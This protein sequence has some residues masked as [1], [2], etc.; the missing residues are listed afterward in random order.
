MRWRIPT[1][2]FAAFFAAALVLGAQAPV[3]GEAAQSV[4]CAAQVALSEQ[5]SSLHATAP[6]HPWD[7]CTG[8][9]AGRSTT[10]D[11]SIIFA[12][13]ED[14]GE[15]DIDFLWYIPRR[16]HAPGSV[17]KLQNGGAVPQVE[18]TYAYFWDQC[19]GTSFSNNIVNKWGVSLGSN[20]CPSRED[21]VEEVA[22]R[23]D[24]VDGGLAFELRIILAERAKT[25]REA[26]EIAARLLDTYG[27]NASGRCLHIVGPDEAW[28]LQMVRGKQY[29]ARRVQDDEVAII[30]NTYSIREVDPED[31]ENFICSPR[32]IEY[33]TER[34]WYDPE[35]G[36]PFDFAAAYADPAAH[37][38][39]YNTDRHWN[40]AR[41]LVKDFPITWKEARTGVLP[42]SVRP[43]RKLTVQDVMAI[44][45]DHYEGTALDSTDSRA[46][47]PHLAP[48]RP[49]C[50]QRSHRTTI[51]QQRSW[52]PREIG[53]VVWRAQ[54]PPCASVFIPWYLGITRIPPAY[55]MA[56]FRADTTS[57]ARIDFHFDMPPST[58]QLGL[59]SS[60]AL[61]KHLRRLID[62]DYAGRI[63]TV[64]KVW[65]RFEAI[66]LD[67]QPSIEEAA[68]A[69]YKKDRQ[70]AL[71]FLTLYCNA[72]AGRSLDVA[73][74][75]IDE[76]PRTK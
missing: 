63:Q 51:I 57:R 30:A 37:R 46:V 70:T 7:N 49:I 5:L 53:T 72:L 41:L 19:P 67:L 42:V 14:D 4:P 2:L 68:L 11:G 3:A 61:F 21:A 55:Q 54:E 1:V 40:L 56:P 69:L 12:K 22:A 28:Q 50:C 16:Q 44:F 27:Y 18:E 48:G 52:L 15:K 10:A 62:E 45:R 43:D 13:T 23:G 74:E 75:M 60:G 38:G 25:A 35:S 29:V 8:L 24:L 59:E 33:A 6:A 17:V 76:L 47:S 31:G 36:K 66:E 73:R 64:R 39:Y 20:A 71:E 58:W 32:L 65:D 9:I 34:G 26:V